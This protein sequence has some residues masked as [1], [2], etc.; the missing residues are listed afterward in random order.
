MKKRMLPVAAAVLLAAALAVAGPAGAGEKA[1]ATRVEIGDEGVVITDESGDT[2]RIGWG[3]GEG[4]DV[5][6]LGEDI[7]R[8]G[9]DVHVPEDQVVEGDVV[10][11]MGDVRVDGYVEGDAVAIGGNLTVGPN[12]HI[13]G[14][15]VAV[16]GTVEKEGGVIRGETVS[17]G[18]GP[19]WCKGS[20]FLMESF[21]SAARRL[22][23]LVMWLVILI[24][25]GAL[26]IA[27][28]R[29]PVDIIKDRASKDAFVNGLIGLL[30]W[31][32]LVPVMVLL[33]IT[34]IGIPI[35]VLLPFVFAVM[36]LLGFVGVAAATGQKFVPAT[37]GGLYKGMAVGVVVLYGLVIVGTLLKLG[38]GPMHL[39]GSILCFIGWAIVFVATTVGLGAVVTSRFGTRE[40][41]RAA[42]Q[43]APA[44]PGGPPGEAAA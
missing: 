1:T 40:K 7:V 4:V 44:S 25:L 22:V 34:V 19:G 32:L 17:L 37:D 3:E 12:G 21:F 39:A 2:T 14:D 9:N 41:V 6:T 36:M 10:A 23:L 33:V 35:A 43:A 8:I 5:E 29:R 18:L 11:V 28:V 15:G 13:D 26:L 27:V 38:P 31:V 20:G 16:G 42:A 30:V 24:L